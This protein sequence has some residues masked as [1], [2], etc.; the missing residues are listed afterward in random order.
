MDNPAADSIQRRVTNAA[1]QGTLPENLGTS[2]NRPIPVHAPRQE[3]LMDNGMGGGMRFYLEEKGNALEI[4][5]LTVK[6]DIIWIK[7][8]MAIIQRAINMLDK[9][10]HDISMLLMQQY[11]EKFCADTRCPRF[12]RDNERLPHVV[13]DN[14]PKIKAENKEVRRSDSYH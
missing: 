1:T 11:P 7:N 8:N 4:D 14:C 10:L 9:G 3:G 2:G 6:Q 5:T 13:D 12:N